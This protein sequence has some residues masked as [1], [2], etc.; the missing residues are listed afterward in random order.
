MSRTVHLEWF[1]QRGPRT[2]HRDARERDEGL[3]FSCTQCGGCCTGPSGYVKFTDD[4]ARAMAT[5]L[6]MPMDEFMRTYT[7]ET[8]MGRSL[9]ER[10][11]EFGYDCVFLDRE[12]APG[13]AVCSLYEARP[14]QCRTWP[15]WTSNLSSEHAWRRAAMECPGIDRGAKATH[16]DEIRRQR[17]IVEM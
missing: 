5:K 8:P 3:R 4:E 15:F 17:A 16:P 2:G 13:K 9:T 14:A 1:D 10:V 11:T 7:H 6:G 12:A